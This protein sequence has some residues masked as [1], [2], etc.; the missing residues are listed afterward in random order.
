MSASSNCVTSIAAINATTASH[1]GAAGKAGLRLLS[2]VFVT[3]LFLRTLRGCQ[4]VAE[5]KGARRNA[6]AGCSPGELGNSVADIVLDEPH[7]L[8]VPRTIGILAPRHQSAADPARQRDGAVRLS[9]Q[10]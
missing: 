10:P 1:C 2:G 3:A 8:P 5:G 9:G 7:G 4:R 6:V